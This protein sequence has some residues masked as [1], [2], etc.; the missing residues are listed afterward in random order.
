MASERDQSKADINST[1]A[2]EEKI[3]DFPGFAMRAAKIG[4]T[5]ISLATFSYLSILGIERATD[6]PDKPSIHWVSDRTTCEN[7]DF[8]V[9]HN[10]GTGKETGEH[11]ATNNRKLIESFGGCVMYLVYGYT[12]QPKESAEVL[13][14]T[15]S[16][17]AKNGEKRK[18]ILVGSSFGGIAWE[19]IA[20]HPA[21]RNSPFIDIIAIVMESAPTSMKDVKGDILGFPA[22]DVANLRIPIIRPFVLANN[23]FD[24]VD[25]KE[26]INF[27]TVKNAAINAAETRPQLVDSQLARTIHGLGPDE[28][29]P[30]IRIFYVHSPETDDMINTVQAL[31]TLRRM[32]KASITELAIEGAGH[33]TSWLDFKYPK[34]EPAYETI[35]KWTNDI[36]NNP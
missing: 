18:L 36:I 12:Y 9:I 31:A 24:I 6:P 11:V 34:T 33:A 5:G 22:S 20:M 29:R 1:N 17:F 27:L 14:S 2:R 35:L 3:F 21:V 30:D 7:S 10:S 23:L 4:A 26:E 13:S 8:I 16:S 19:E 28:I 32:T 25:R 15:I